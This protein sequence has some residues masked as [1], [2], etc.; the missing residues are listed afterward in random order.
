[1]ASGRER[2]V[3]VPDERPVTTMAFTADGR[4]AVGLMYRDGKGGLFPPLPDGRL[5]WRFAIPSGEHLGEEPQEHPLW[6]TSVAV[7]PDGSTLALG[8][9]HSGFRVLI[10]DAAGQVRKTTKHGGYVHEIAFA[11]GGDRFAVAAGG[12][13][14]LWDVR[15]AKKLAECARHR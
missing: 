7:S 2:A 14:T 3:L 4:T 15:T 9:S 13:V 11:P 10:W 1:L 6:T 8:D 5:A 12:K